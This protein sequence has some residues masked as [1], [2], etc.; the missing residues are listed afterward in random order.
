[1]TLSLKSVGSWTVLLLILMQF[2]PLNRINPLT[3][4]DIDA[5]DVIK[6]SLKKACYDC[7]S[8]ETRWTALAF[9][10]PISWMLSSTVS[11]GRNVM[12]FSSWNNKNKAQLNLRKTEISHIIT[13]G[14][15]H[16]SLYYLWNPQAKLND[17]ETKIVLDWLNNTIEKQPFPLKN[18]EKNRLGKTL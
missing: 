5:P 10:A 16:Q 17:R 18:S 12:N 3:T 2:I 7:H 1:M 15:V 4:S 11:S 9:T 13:G 6:K 14:T 8:N